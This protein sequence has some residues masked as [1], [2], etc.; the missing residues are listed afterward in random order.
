MLKKVIRSKLRALQVFA[1]FSS[2]VFWKLDTV[3]V[4]KSSP[5]FLRWSCK[6]ENAAKGKEA[7]QGKFVVIVEG[8]ARN[9]FWGKPLE[10]LPVHS[11]LQL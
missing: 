11:R 1:L 3:S 5:S 4:S 10:F 7:F 8:F 9:F 2:G 6:K